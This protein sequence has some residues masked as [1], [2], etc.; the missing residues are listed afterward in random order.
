MVSYIGSRAAHHM[1]VGAFP[2]PLSLSEDCSSESH[3]CLLSQVLL[4]AC[5]HAASCKSATK[6][7]SA[8]GTRE[9]TSLMVK[10][11]EGWFQTL[12]ES[13]RRGVRL[14]FDDV[15]HKKCQTLPF[16]S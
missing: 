12:L 4:G 9:E 10:T 2:F 14:L 16:M 6:H 7:L 13:C 5:I 3:F 8:G 15:G 11:Y 1:V